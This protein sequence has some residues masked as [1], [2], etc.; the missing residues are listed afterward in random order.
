MAS[1]TCLLLMKRTGT[2]TITYESWS[3]IKDSPIS[4]AR[5]T[6]RHTTVVRKSKRSLSA[7]GNRRLESRQTTTP[8]DYN[9]AQGAGSAKTPSR[10]VWRGF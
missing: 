5:P 8:P 2:E 3:Y 6:G 4:A 1:T 10:L 9:D 7:P